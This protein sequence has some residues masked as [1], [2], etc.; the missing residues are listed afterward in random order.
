[1][2]INTAKIKYDILKISEE[3]RLAKIKNHEVINATLGT[4]YNEN[5]E[6][7]AYKTV[8]GI[9]NNL[10][11][12]EYYSYATSDGGS[13]YEDAVLNWVFKSKKIEICN[14]TNVHAVSTPGGTGA[15]FASM[16]ESLNAGDEI[17][18]PDYCWEP[19]LAMANLNSFIPKRFP[20]FNDELKYN[21]KAFI[22]SCQEMLEKQDKIV[23]LIN[24]PCNNPTGYTMSMEEFSEIIDYLNNVKGNVYIIYDIAYYDYSENMRE[25]LQKL[26]MLSEMNE[27][28]VTFI[29]FSASKS[30][31]TYGMRLGAQIMMSKNPEIS[32]SLY[33]K[34]CIISR[35]HWSNINKAGISMLVK[36][37][38][39]P[40][41]KE[42][43]LVELNE[44]KQILLKRI[45]VFLEEAN[46]CGLKVF[47]SQ[48][49]F[50]LTV[51]CANPP[52]VY[53]KLKEKRIYVIPLETS[54]RI[55]ICS[56]SVRE[57]VGL[58]TKIKSAIEEVL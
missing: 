57:T 23:A 19:Y 58:A 50:F 27:H 37:V 43:F 32:E 8:K 20:M 10:E 12:V 7:R 3:A 21:T 14:T 42:K 33:K 45:K 2:S 55:A 34:S 38:Y 31:C 28:V 53:E 18:I 25:Q 36:L 9:I 49:G 4:Y 24:D 13:A 11:D 40:L 16:M 46:E 17:L 15:L 6:F 29:T 41:F 1:M 26:K 5:N 56:V 54:I 44:N 51:P 30:F 47:D 52:L 22:C 48:G 39:N 35:T